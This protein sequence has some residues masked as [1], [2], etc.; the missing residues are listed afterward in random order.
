MCPAADRGDGENL[1]IVLRTGPD[2]TK[3]RVEDIFNIALAKIP[4][5]PQYMTRE[6]TNGPPKVDEV[7]AADYSAYQRLTNPDAPL[8][9]P[10]RKMTPNKELEVRQLPASVPTWEF[11]LLGPMPREISQVDIVYEG[12]DKTPQ[13]LIPST[14]AG[15]PLTITQFASYVLKPPKDKTPLKYT[16]YVRELAGSEPRQIPGEWPRG[17]HFFLV[18]LNGFKGDRESLAAMIKS[19]DVPNA[20]GFFE[21]KDDVTLALA[22]AK[23]S[24]YVA[25]RNAIE[26]NK[27]YVNA[28]PLKGAAPRRAFMLFPLSKEQF[29]IQLAELR[30]MGD[31]ELPEHVRKSVV[32]PM[33]DALVTA[34]SKPMWYEMPLVLDDNNLAKFPA[35]SFGRVLSLATLD[36]NKKIEP[37]EY[38]KLLER[39]PQAYQIVVYEF[40]DGVVRR[41]LRYTNEES[42]DADE[43]TYP[44]NGGPMDIWA[45]KIAQLAGS[46]PAAKNETK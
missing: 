18:R 43:A 4:K 32:T 9:E 8:I 37:V 21:I 27:V 39:F 22:E 15:A 25:L 42:K 16:A 31:A 28:P 12:K 41:A 35:G 34:D 23:S 13:K 46:R 6:I 24:K 3:P 14:D 29:D 5:R 45:V 1:Q 2:L 11:S 20:F 26:G 17:D 10:P 30:E 38:Q 36:P 44:A 19:K 33:E 7:T 40:D